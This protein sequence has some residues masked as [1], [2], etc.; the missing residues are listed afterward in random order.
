[1]YAHPRDTRET[2]SEA[3]KGKRIDNLWYSVHYN[4]IVYRKDGDGQRKGGQSRANKENK[5]YIVKKI[6]ETVK[7]TDHLEKLIG[8]VLAQR[9]EALVDIA[10][11]HRVRALKG[12]LA[13][14]V[15]HGLGGGHIRETSLTLHPIYG[16]PY[17]PA[18]SIKGVVRRWFIDAFLD[19]EEKRLLT[20][21]EEAAQLGRIVFGCQ[22]KKGAVQFYDLFFPEQLTL[23]PDVMTPH[24]PDYYRGKQPAT[25]EQ[26]PIPIPFYT[27]IASSAEWYVSLPRET[28]AQV[29]K[30]TFSSEQLADLIVTWTKRALT[31][32]GIG[33]KTSSGYGRFAK[34]TDV[35]EDKMT[36]LVQ[37]RQEQQQWREKQVWEEEAKRKEEKERQRLVSMSPTERL[38]Y[39]I[40]QL[41]EKA[42]DIERS[43][44]VLFNQ[45]KEVKDPDVAAALKA[46]WEKTGQWAVNKKKQKQYEKVQHIKKMLGE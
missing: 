43:K 35:T 1:M 2:Y 13:V 45:V 33:S 37:H 21:D 30:E 31:E 22:E 26:N 40:N 12:E 3:D 10:D 27:V 17:I 11:R 9:L 25:D 15:I 36:S 6:R 23:E 5:K 7:Q 16:V 41:S 44:G 19:G 46:Y 20:S 4:Q 14:A 18:S 32:R 28:R 34:V 39:E 8:E 42:E 38:I 29:G 24:F